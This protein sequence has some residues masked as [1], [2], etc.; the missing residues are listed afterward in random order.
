MGHAIPS[1]EWD[2][3]N[4]PLG[5]LVIDLLSWTEAGPVTIESREVRAK[6]GELLMVDFTAT[7]D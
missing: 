7:K 4:V 5:P 1:D 3:L 6:E 2:T